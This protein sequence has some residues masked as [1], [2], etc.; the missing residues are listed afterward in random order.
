MGLTSFTIIS[1]I[2]I[3]S[4]LF[5]S[6]AVFVQSKGKEN[7]LAVT[8]FLSSLAV[9]FYLLSAVTKS[10]FLT[11][12]FSS[13]YFGSITLMMP[14]L[15]LFIL[16]YTGLRGVFS[17]KLKV[18][19]IIIHTIAFIDFVNLMINPFYEFVI[20]YNYIEES[21]RH[22]EYNPG[23]MYQLHLLFCYFVIFIVF[24]LLVYKIFTTPSVYRQKYIVVFA[25]ILLVVV[26]NAVYLFFPTNEMLDYSVLFYSIIGFFMYWARFVYTKHGMLNKVRQTVLDEL[27]Q[28]VFLFDIDNNLSMCN[29]V[30]AGFFDFPIE[31]KTVDYT[32]ED[33]SKLCAFPQNI[34]DVEK[35][36]H[37]QWI[38]KQE[39]NQSIYRV[40]VKKLFDRK[41]KRCIGTL[42]VMT[43][44]TLEMD[45]ITGFYTKNSFET[46]FHSK[47]AFN[48]RYPCVVTICDINKLTE[49]NKLAGKKEG[50]RAIQILAGLMKKHFPEGSYFSRHED[51]NLV[52]VCSRSNVEHMRECLEVLR[53]ELKKVEGFPFELEIQSA[54]AVASEKNPDILRATSVAMFSMRTKK[55]MD[56]SSSHSSLLDSLAQT[57]NE[58]DS[59]TRAHVQ[60][61]RDM[62]E[63]LGKRLNFTDM[64]LSQL[65]LLCL[66]H[67]IGKL[68][69]PLDI[70][71]KP[72][73][74]NSAE[75]DVMKSHVEKGYRI[76]NASSELGDI[77]DLILHH[78][79]SWNGKGYPDGL[80]QEAIPL[81]SRVIAVVDTYDAMR[82]DRPY[83][84]AVSERE[85]REEIKRCAGVQFDPTIAS[86][87]LE[88]LEE[89]H[90]L[91]DLPVEPKLKK[92]NPY[93]V[94]TP[95]GVS[96][97]FE[98]PVEENEDDNEIVQPIKHAKYRINADME[99]ISVD[100][101]FYE[102]TGYEPQDLQ[103]YHLKHTDLLPPEDVGIYLQKLGKI[104]SSDNEAFIEHRLLRKDGSNRD[105]VCFGK[106]IYD[107][108]LREE[109][110][111]I[112]VFDISNTRAFGA[113][114]RNE[115]ESAK[116][117]AEKWE[118]L[119]RRDSL[120]GLLNHESFINDVEIELLALD[121]K[122]VLVLM[123]IDAFKN[124]NDTYGHFAGDKMIALAAMMLES[125]VREIGFAGRLGGDEFGAVIKVPKETSDDEIE[126]KVKHCFDF[127][128]NATSSQEKAATISIGAAYL[129][130]PGRFATLYQEADKALYRAKDKGRKQY[131][132]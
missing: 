93:E 107:S 120:T 45:L 128:M 70:L 32:L 8:L 122:I 25:G 106:Q 116:R 131:S 54:I 21:I 91:E 127:V 79:E 23:V 98:K 17:K 75:W 95:R 64:Q 123:D 96:E 10:Y 20:S 39:E 22:W 31:N 63:L 126:A 11:S 6:G 59:T 24:S 53:K 57:L 34:V 71:N 65:A 119:M 2:V 12:L 19:S 16:K 13:L 84:K 42:V 26:M 121:Q 15:L 73:K 94:S 90:P 51:A 72:G 109:V 28:P 113:L 117:S 37:F 88:L 92:E 97:I 60:R 29:I 108:A 82:N 56:G 125:S 68:G 58:S 104:L 27:D 7:Y 49:I 30:A 130:Q 61:T 52:S 9:V 129:K 83:H 55:L 77:A 44:T 112:A 74:L 111:E 103:I 85:A 78:H 101:N 66:L 81:L 100:N 67:D 36:I 38:P 4:A 118:S 46:F 35:N 3:L 76:A 33:F 1:I 5:V 115:R 105:V 48:V 87:F 102:L 124:Y 14:H 132:F 18:F 86:A 114:K 80:K 69:I 43:D 89:I 47:E 99:I 62:G 110:S 40:D 41:G 50:D